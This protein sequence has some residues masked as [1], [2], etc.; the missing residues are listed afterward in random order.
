MESNDTMAAVNICADSIHDSC[1]FK[2]VVCCYERTWNWL[3]N[4]SLTYVGRTEL[5]RWLYQAGLVQLH[6]KNGAWVVM[7]QDLRQG[8]LV[9]VLKS[10]P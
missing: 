2:I 5:A 4:T 7:K 10:V 6:V 1:C 9:V 8:S 3:K